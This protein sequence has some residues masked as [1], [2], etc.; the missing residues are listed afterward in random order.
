MCQIQYPTQPFLTLDFPPFHIHVRVRVGLVGWLAR[1]SYAVPREVGKVGT[2]SPTF[3]EPVQKR[4]DG[5]EAMFTRQTKAAQAQQRSDKK[6]KRES[7]SP[8]KAEE[9]EEKTEMGTSAPVSAVVPSRPVKRSKEAKG[10][11]IKSDDKA[12]ADSEE[13]S[14]DVEILLSGPSSSSPLQ[15]QSVGPSPL[16]THE[17]THRINGIFANSEAIES[18]SFEGCQ[19]KD[20]ERGKWHH[21]HSLLAIGFAAAAATAA[22]GESHT[23]T[24]KRRDELCTSHAHLLRIPHSPNFIYQLC[25]S[26]PFFSF[27][28]PSDQTLLSICLSFEHNSPPHHP[29]LLRHAR[30]RTRSRRNLTCRHRPPSRDRRPR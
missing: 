3:I 4:K 22:E 11:P 7:V 6:R 27:F 13:G 23:Y 18:F 24:T 29:R 9:E 16:L 26:T 1:Y 30:T 19:A 20:E 12:A 5:I 25:L 28:F 2:E 10:H 21:S 8:T 15:G 17:M 14:S